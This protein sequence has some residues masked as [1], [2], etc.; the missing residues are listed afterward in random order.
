M[1]L[2]EAPNCAISPRLRAHF[3]VEAPGGDVASGGDHLADRPGDVADHVIGDTDDA[4]EADGG[5][6]EERKDD[7]I[8]GLS[9]SALEQTGEQGADHLGFVASKGAH[10]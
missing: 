4:D 9:V 5:D 10:A 7:L 8:A 1:V 6:G 2:N 3:V